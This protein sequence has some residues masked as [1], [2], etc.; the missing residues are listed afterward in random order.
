MNDCYV[1]NVFFFEKKDIPYVAI[2]HDPMQYILRKVYSGTVLRYFFFALSP[3]LF[4]LERKFVE[5][6]S[7][8]VTVSRVHTSFIKDSYGITPPV[9]FAGC[10]VGKKILG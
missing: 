10:D 8:V 4:F 7:A 3:L 6:A 9:L 5:K 2:I 1:W